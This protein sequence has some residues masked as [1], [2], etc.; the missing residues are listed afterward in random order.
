M[1][2]EIVLDM[3]TKTGDNHLTFDYQ[4]VE[5]RDEIKSEER[6]ENLSI[7]DAVRVL[8]SMAANTEFYEFNEISTQT[9][10]YETVESSMQTEY[11]TKEIG[12]QTDLYEITNEVSIQTDFF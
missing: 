10:A 6:S 1:S 9:D 7:R 11:Q 12:I 5:T 4:D 8:E 2:E 3:F